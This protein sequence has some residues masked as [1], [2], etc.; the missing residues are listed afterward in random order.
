VASTGAAPVTLDGAGGQGAGKNR[1]VQISDPGTQVTSVSGALTVRGTGGSGSGTFNQG[2]SVDSRAQVTSVSGAIRFIGTGGSGS[3]TFNQ[4]VFVGSGAQVTSVSGAITILGTGGLSISGSGTTDV[5]PGGALPLLTTATQPSQ[6]VTVIAGGGGPLISGQSSISSA[7]GLTSALT[8][9]HATGAAGGAIF[10]DIANTEVVLPAALLSLQGRSDS[11]GREDI[12]SGADLAGILLTGARPRVKLSRQKGQPFGAVPSIQPGEEDTAP[13]AGTTE[14]ETPWRKFPI[15]LDNPLRRKHAN[16]MPDPRIPLP[17]GVFLE[18]EGT[19]PD[20]VLRSFVPT[21]A[22]AE[23][24]LSV[25]P[26]QGDEQPAAGDG[27]RWIEQILAHH[28]GRVSLGL[29]LLMA[30]FGQSGVLSALAKGGREEETRGNHPPLGSS[31]P[32]GH[33]R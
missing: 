18:N 8:E 15:G 19:G 10:G 21:A 23:R 17:E 4:G 32:D 9:A 11:P 22:G 25:G 14:E 2:I 33:R 12:P 13:E 7:T 3:G 31:P 1:G 20:Q 28:A 29:A 30:G 16:R 27:C 24:R 5:S 6:S 26:A